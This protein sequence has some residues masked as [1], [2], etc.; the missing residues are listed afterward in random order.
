MRAGAQADPPVSSAL[1]SPNLGYVGLG[2]GLEIQPNGITVRAKTGLLVP[3]T[4]NWGDEH[5]EFRLLDSADMQSTINNL[6]LNAWG[7]YN[8]FVAKAKFSFDYSQMHA[9]QGNHRY[10]EIRASHTWTDSI[11]DATFNSTALKYSRDAVSFEKFLGNYAVTGVT[12]KQVIRIVFDATISSSLSNQQIG[13]AISGSF[14]CFSAG[15]SIALTTTQLNAFSNVSIS[16]YVD[17]AGGGKLIKAGAVGDLQTLRDAVGNEIGLWGS[18]AVDTKNPGNIDSVAVTPWANI[19]PGVT[20]APP[21]GPNQVE[22]TS[23]IAVFVHLQ[24]ALVRLT[25]I[26]TQDTNLNPVLKNYL[27]GPTGKLHEVNSDIIKQGA[28]MKSLLKANG[29]VQDPNIY[30]QFDDPDAAQWRVLSTLT[31]PVSG[32]SIQL[33]VIEIYSNARVHPQLLYN[34][35]DSTDYLNFGGISWNSAIKTVTLNDGFIT[36]TLSGNSIDE[37][38]SFTKQGNLDRVTGI[39]HRYALIRWETPGPT[40][41]YT[42]Q[43]ISDNGAT[44]SSAIDW[45]GVPSPQLFI[46][47]GSWHTWNGK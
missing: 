26:Q 30:F 36:T 20:V 34:G 16:I 10:W 12:Y 24:Q 35:N 19:A 28:Y 29:L 5:T 45:L 13:A 2:R 38:L 14:G 41:D 15:A 4:H 8:G 9:Y 43:L 1:W 37:N 11:T 18:D 31:V 7:E 42:L 46:S 39:P 25:E 17:G 22:L 33:L 23:A 21:P 3:A 6:H 44:F 32:A 40:S 27:F 47:A